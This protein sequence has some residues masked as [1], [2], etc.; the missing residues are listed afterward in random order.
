MPVAAITLHLLAVVIWVGGVFFAYLAA[1]PVLAELDPLLRARLWAG[2][3]RRFF[4]WVWAAIAVLLVTGVYMVFSSFEG[5]ANAPLFV[6]LM[7][8]LGLLMMALFG[9]IDFGPYGKLKAAV[10]SNDADLALKSMGRIRRVMAAVLAL[11]L[12]VIVIAMSGMY[13]SSD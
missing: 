2:I 8:G 3:F 5:F 10:A 9:H 1:R 4:P 12:A 6:D 7:M 13:L 11:G